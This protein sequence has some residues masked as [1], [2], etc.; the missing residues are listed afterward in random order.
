VWTALSLTFPLDHFFYFGVRKRPVRCLVHQ[1]LTFALPLVAGAIV[2]V[3]M[4][5]GDGGGCIGCEYH[6]VRAFLAAAAPPSS[7]ARSRGHQFKN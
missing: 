4:S 3:V 7:S 1:C 2:C 5:D 6:R